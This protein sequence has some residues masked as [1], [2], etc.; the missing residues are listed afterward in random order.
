[1][2]VT[3]ERI[4]VAL[5]VPAPESGSI[6]EQQWL[7]WVEDAVMLIESRKVEVKFDGQLDEAKV[8]YVV[9]EA[10]VKH[11][12]KPDDATQVT[13][14]TDDSSSSKTYQSGKGRVTIVDEWWTLLG[15][16]EQSGAFSIDML[17]NGSAGHLPWCSFHF[18][19]FACSC[20]ASIAGK[21]IYEV[22][23]E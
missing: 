20:G 19:H 7:M 22:G 8:D 21:P 16:V 15:L 10:V 5:G 13:V 6:Q 11:V 2:P 4:A 1:M 23:Y 17:P 12:R 14:S 18:G 9:R 3:P